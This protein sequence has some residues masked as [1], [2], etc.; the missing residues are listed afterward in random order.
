[1][2][3]APLTLLS[4]G[5]AARHMRFVF[6]PDNDVIYQVCPGQRLRVRTDPSFTMSTRQAKGLTRNLFS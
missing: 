6:L 4:E 1:M 3:Y 2:R 5:S